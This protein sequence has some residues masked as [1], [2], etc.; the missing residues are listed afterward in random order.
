MIIPSFIW[1]IKDK[2]RS[3]GVEIPKVLQEKFA[4]DTAFS[5]RLLEI[6]RTQPDTP[7][8]R[9]EQLQILKSP[10]IYSNF[11]K[12]DMYAAAFRVEARHPFMDVRLI[13]FCLGLPSNQSYSDG[14]S[15]VIMRR[16]MKGIVPDAIRWRADK[17][18][19]SE[20]LQ[21]LFFHNND[22]IIRD[23]LKAE[24]ELSDILNMDTL[25]SL[26]NKKQQLSQRDIDALMKSVNLLYW[27]HKKNEKIYSSA[28]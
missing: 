14:W 10:Y 19:L 24:G 22:K 15:R 6:N 25:K 23:L 18:D 16:A 3:R 7:N 9:E 21:F 11:E 13:E 26:Y 27:L 1:K 2:R 28:A 4:S 20:P 12:I 17:A 8:L 5:A